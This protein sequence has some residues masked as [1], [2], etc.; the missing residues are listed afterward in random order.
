MLTNF[1]AMLRDAY[2]GGYAV[3]SFNVYN[4][5][6]MRGVVDAAKAAGVSRSSSPLAPSTSPTCR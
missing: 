5:E 6:T 2:T 3:G 1:N 4:Y